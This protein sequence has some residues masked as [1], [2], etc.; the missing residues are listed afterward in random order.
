MASASS[1]RRKWIDSRRFLDGD[2]KTRRRGGFTRIA[3]FEAIQFV[4]AVC[5]ATGTEAHDL[6]GEIIEPLIRG[7]FRILS[8]RPD[9]QFD[10]TRILRPRDFTGQS[11]RFQPTYVSSGL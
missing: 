8:R 10:Y 9:C 2:D 7:V 5:W 1:D 11:H 6:R 4:A 3:L